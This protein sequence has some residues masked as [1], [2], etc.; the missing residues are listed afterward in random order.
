MADR[1][2][3]IARALARGHDKLRS[4][5]LQEQCLKLLEGD[6]QAYT[7]IATYDSHWYLDRR[8]YSD[9]I[10]GKRYKRL[11]IDDVDG[12]RLGKLKAMT[13]VQIGDDIYTFHGKDSFISAVPS[14]E[15]KVVHKGPRI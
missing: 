12:C 5:F 15:F 14:Y 13:A 2:T 7:I 3:R 8:E 10:A 4:I 9:V 11:V 1:G 6:Q